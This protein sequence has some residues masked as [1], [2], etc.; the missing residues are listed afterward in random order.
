MAEFVEVE[1][2]QNLVNKEVVTTPTQVKYASAGNFA[3]LI[4]A[5]LLAFDKGF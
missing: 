1:Y 2:V 5:A 4:G 3:G